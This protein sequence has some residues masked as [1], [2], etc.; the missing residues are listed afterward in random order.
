MP[1]IL[2]D[3]YH[4]FLSAVFKRDP[5]AFET[6]VWSWDKSCVVMLYLNV[7]ALSFAIPQHLHNY[8]VRNWK[9]NIYDSK[10]TG[11][12]IIT[13]TYCDISA[14]RRVLG[15]DYKDSWWNCSL[16][17]RGKTD[18]VSANA[19][20]FQGMST[21]FP[22]GCVQGKS[23]GVRNPRPKMGQIM[24]SYQNVSVRCLAVPQHL[25][26]AKLHKIDEVYSYTGCINK[27]DS[28]YSVI[29]TL[30][31]SQAYECT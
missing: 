24:R 28:E 11:C 13:N 5:G 31:D 18:E 8:N 20:N 7:L 10:Q 27:E 12:I 1:T 6:F 4:I 2:W 19:H 23:K 26:R 30:K 29:K 25:Q 17:I 3:K 22:F 21:V 14:L 9:I 15:F 16:N